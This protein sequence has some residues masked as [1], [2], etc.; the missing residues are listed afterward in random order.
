MKNYTDQ[1]GNKPLTPIEPPSVEGR[2]ELAEAAVEFLYELGLCGCPNYEGLTL[3][4]GAAVNE[5]NVVEFR[6][7]YIDPL[8]KLGVMGSGRISDQMGL[9][10]L[11]TKLANEPAG[12][13]RIINVGA[14]VARAKV[15]E[16][17]R[18][19]SEKTL[20]PNTDEVGETAVRSRLLIQKA[21]VVEKPKTMVSYDVLQRFINEEN[22]DLTGSGLLKSWFRTYQNFYK[23]YGDAERWFPSEDSFHFAG[24]LDDLR[25]AAAFGPMTPLFVASPYG[26][27]FNEQLCNALHIF[28]NKEVLL[29]IDSKHMWKVP[30]SQ[31]Y[32]GDFS[33]I[34]APK[35]DKTMPNFRICFMPA[36][37]LS[38]T[39]NIGRTMNLQEYLTFM[40]YNLIQKGQYVDE[41][42]RIY[43]AEKTHKG[44]TVSVL[45]KGSGSL[46]QIMSMP[47][48]ANIMKLSR[49]II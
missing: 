48:T 25:A 23:D 27:S 32:P 46:L 28:G 47:D 10:L 26:L 17:M 16:F 49:S 18:K 8:V 37:C 6:N 2:I 4:L 45:N 14:S 11:I 29:G 24:D 7:L 21:A 9:L 38:R 43:L 31:S 42:L 34:V 39:E 20:K 41:N 1:L 33:E 13:P 19:G 15:S 3:Y 35:M 44:E 22:I 40:A 30:A 12:L 5:L 36:N